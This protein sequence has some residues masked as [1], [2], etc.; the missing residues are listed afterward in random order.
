VVADDCA[1][2]SDTTG[3]GFGLVGLTERVEAA[4]GA[5]TAGPVDSGWRVTAVLPLA[6]A[7][8]ECPS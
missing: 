7:L 1:S 6:T 5:L 8:P 2:T 3:T 4:G